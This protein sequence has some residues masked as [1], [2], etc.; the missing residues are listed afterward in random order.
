MSL[1]DVCYLSVL[2]WHHNGDKSA[3]V[4]RDSTLIAFLVAQDEEVGLLSVDGC[5]EIL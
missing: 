1:N 5:L 3:A 2:V 4:V